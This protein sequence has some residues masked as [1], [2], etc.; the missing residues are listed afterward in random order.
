MKRVA[1]RA[2]RNYDGP[3]PDGSAYKKI[4]NSWDVCD[5][6]FDNAH[7][8][9]KPNDPSAFLGEDGCWYVSK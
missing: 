3:I 7:R 8:S 5:Y 4:F 6:V 9:K 1:N 2:V